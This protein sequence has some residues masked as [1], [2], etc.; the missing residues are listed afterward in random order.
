MSK[1]QWQRSKLQSN[2]DY[3][4]NQRD[5]QGAGKKTIPNTG[6]SIA[7]VIQNMLTAGEINIGKSQLVTRMM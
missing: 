1:R 7:P 4:E 3:R 2:S 5:A 6:A